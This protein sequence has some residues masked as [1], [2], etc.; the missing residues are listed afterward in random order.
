MRTP[1][2]IG[3]CAAFFAAA[4]LHPAARWEWEWLARS[5]D[6]TDEARLMLV[7][8]ASGSGELGSRLAARLLLVLRPVGDG[9]GEG[10]DIDT[11]LFTELQLSRE[12]LE[13]G[14]LLL[15][16]C[17][18]PLFRSFCAWSRSRSHSSSASAR[19]TRR[20]CSTHALASNCTC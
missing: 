1:L 18:L 13:A 11:S 3:S 15:R 16:F 8:L 19:F 6:V 14:L 5:I 17:L 20:I 4:P 12:A 9:A 2:L 7:G 10:S